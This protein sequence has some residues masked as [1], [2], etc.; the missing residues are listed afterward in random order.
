M[1][2]KQFD[3]IRIISLPERTDRR[4]LMT[5]DLQKAGLAGDPRVKFFDAIR[6]PDAGLFG[7]A[8]AHGCYRSHLQLLKAAADEEQSIL[9]LEDDCT[10]LPS[11]YEYALPGS[12]D[13]FYGGYYPKDPDD[14]HNTEIIGSHFMGFSSVAATKARIFLDHLLDPRFPP[15]PAAANDPGFDPAIRPPI[16]GAYV[17]F[18]R[19]H[20]ELTTVF[21]LLSVQRPS[22]SDIGP[23]RFFDRLPILRTAAALARRFKRT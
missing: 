1:L 3:R 12:W 19:A 6:M 11:I 8:G 9:I 17:W 10:F 20:P 23:Q 5:L 13:V 22:R 7:S 2:F 18:R 4:K 15:D 21:E 16:D 14:L